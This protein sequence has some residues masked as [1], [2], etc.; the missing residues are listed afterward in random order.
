MAETRGLSPV[1]ITKPRLRGGTISLLFLG[2]FLVGGAPLELQGQQATATADPAIQELRQIGAVSRAAILHRD[3]NPLRPFLLNDNFREVIDS[4]LAD[5]KG[6]FNCYLFDSSCLSP[7]GTIRR[8][9]FEILSTMRTPAMLVILFPPEAPLY[10]TLYFYDRSRI[11]ENALRRGLQSRRFRC[12]QAPNQIAVWEFE[13]GISG[14]RTRTI[15]NYAV[16][17]TCSPLN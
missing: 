17:T 4:L 12:E 8:S 9:V 3:A 16:D 5:K 2:V 11:S 10:G 14:W 6:D 13:A 1:F 15:F 7:R